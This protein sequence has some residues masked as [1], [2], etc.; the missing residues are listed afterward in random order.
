[1]KRRN[2]L[3]LAA[4]LGIGLIGGMTP[5]ANAPSVAQPQQVAQR[6]TVLLVSVAASLQD[7]MQ[8]IQT[9]F[10]EAHPE[11]TLNYNFG[12]S[13]ALQQQIEQGAPV[14]VFISAGVPQMDALEEQDLLLSGSRQDL[15]GNSLVLITPS[16]SALELSD[17][18]DLT[19]PDVERISVGEF[20][21]V[22]A[23]QY[24][25]QV[26]NNLDI[27]AAIQ[28]KLVFANNVRGVLAAVESG[29]VDAG[30]VYATDAAI[31]ERVTVVAIAPA[32]LHSPIT[33]PLAILDEAAN[34]DAAQT[35]VEYLT[36]DAARAVFEDFGFTVLD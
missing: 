10:E 29:N 15:L 25:E 5:Q 34:P 30:V 8:V 21:S 14:D 9:N 27:L 20:R 16:D 7:V 33:Y 17:F 23:G 24:A 2:V 3:L 1:M 31:S 28:P 18:S 32:D 12:S 19:Q 6:Q 11:I 35:L 13:G 22:P 4:A 26:F 36:S